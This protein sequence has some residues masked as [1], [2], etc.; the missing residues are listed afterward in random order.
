[1]L[2]TFEAGLKKHR[3][4]DADGRKLAANLE[5]EAHLVGDNAFGDASELISFLKL[6]AGGCA[7]A[8]R[9]TTGLDAYWLACGSFELRGLAI[10]RDHLPPKL[11]HYSSN[12]KLVATILEKQLGIAARM[13]FD[14]G[15]MTPEDAFHQLSLKWTS[16]KLTPKERLG[17]GKAVFATFEH[18]AGAPRNSA[19][20]MTQALALRVSVRVLSGEQILFEFTYPTDSVENHRFPTVA[21]AG[22]WH[23]FEPAGET[24]PNPAVPETCC[25]WTK[26]LGAQ[27]PQPEIV[28]ANGPLRILSA[29]P[30]FVGRIKK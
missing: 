5:L 4:A 2:A 30:R 20:A 14:A 24:E 3:A 6:C 25:G 27:P 11:L 22:S 1:M 21:D 7:G 18:R 26:P 8:A 12:R 16:S 17:G 29:S 9:A 19:L 10:P 13:A 15:T 23:L 28:H